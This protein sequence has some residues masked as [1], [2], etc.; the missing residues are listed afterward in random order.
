MHLADLDL[1]LGSLGTN[2]RVNFFVM[3]FPTVRLIAHALNVILSARRCFNV[4]IFA[5]VIHL[6]YLPAS[7]LPPKLRP[8]VSLIIT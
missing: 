6:T 2:R 7:P 1:G 3:D 4:Y 5:D 8:T